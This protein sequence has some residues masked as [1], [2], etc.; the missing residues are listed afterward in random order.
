MSKPPRIP[1]GPK[2]KGW[3]RF[4]VITVTVL[5]AWWGYQELRHLSAI[6]RL[7]SCR[8]YLIYKT[9]EVYAEENGGMYP[10]L[11]PIFG[12]L[13]YD[14][15]LCGKFCYPVGDHACEFDADDPETQSLSLSR[16]EPDLIDDWSYVYLGYFIEDEQ[17]GLAWID[18]YKDI[19]VLGGSF[20]EDL[21]VPDGKGN[22]GGDKLYR[23]RQDKELPEELSYLED[24]LDEIPVVIEWP[25]NH[26][27]YGAKVVFA[28]GHVEILKYPGAFPMSETFISALKE[29]D[30]EA[31]PLAEDDSI[32]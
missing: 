16:N 30:L 3:R 14:T 26:G 21:T 28:D 24:R 17:Q 29:L 18:A 11:S 10:P 2:S 13:T 6:A 12:R 9:S 23:L 31:K 8:P 19:G 4:F 5:A 7:A 1:A 22:G 15:D 20:E 32:G 27:K 25:G